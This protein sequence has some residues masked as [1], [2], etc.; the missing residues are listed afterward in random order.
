[1]SSNIAL[2]AFGHAVSGSAG[3]AFSTATLYPLDLITT[4]LKLQRLDGQNKYDGTLDAFKKIIKEDG[5]V[6]ALYS[7]LG[8]DV[9]KSIVDSFLFFGIYNYMRQHSPKS[10]T[11]LRE[12]LMGA[13]AGASARFFTTPIS[14]AV[15]RTQVSSSEKG[16]LR[17]LAI[18]KNEGGILGLWS[19]YSATLVLTLNPSLTFLLNRRLTA[20]IIPALEDDDVP[21]AWIAFLLAAMSKAVA[22]GL[23]YPFQ[24]GKTK[25]Q[26]AQKSEKGDTSGE[27]EKGY[28]PPDQQPH[29]QNIVPVSALAE[30]L[31]QSIFGV[32]WRII[33]SEGFLALY[34]GM[35]GELLK[36]FIS[37]GLTMLTKGMIHRFILRLWQLFAPRLRKGGVGAT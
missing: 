9:A 26:V 33:S 21:V 7:G 6:A 19:G 3:T 34:G 18:I 32:I 22:T 31:K 35:Q 14:T 17:M 10:P 27:L 23:T 13:I 11:V 5:G 36:G 4:R 25:L 28:T 15:T 16:L 12:L 29:Q 1:M 2:D 37:H 8:S 30:G 20:R 24:T